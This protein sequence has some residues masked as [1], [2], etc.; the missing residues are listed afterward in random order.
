VAEA[1]EMP[2]QMHRVLDLMVDTQ[3]YGVHRILTR[4]LVDLFLRA[5]SAL[6]LLDR[7]SLEQALALFHWAVE[8]ILEVVVE[9][10]A[11]VAVAVAVAAVS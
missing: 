3:S 2:V 11:V 1:L 8:D 10:T 5:A 7:L 6:M 9:T 4:L